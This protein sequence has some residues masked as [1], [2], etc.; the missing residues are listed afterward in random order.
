MSASHL[1]FIFP[2]PGVGRTGDDH[3]GLALSLVFR[4][5]VAHLTVAGGHDDHGEEVGEEE[6]DDVVDVVQHGL[7]LPTVWPYEDT[8]S[9]LRAA[10]IIQLVLH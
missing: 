3:P 2:D 10:T 4:K 6:E 7:P 1:L 8:D 9:L 5:E